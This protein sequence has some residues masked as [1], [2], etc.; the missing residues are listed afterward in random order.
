MKDQR[1]Y[2]LNVLWFK[3]GGGS[4]RYKDYLKAANSFEREVGAR[5]MKSFVP[6]ES[7]VGDFD[8][9]LIFFVEY[10]NL[11]AFK[12]LMGN[13][14]YQTIVQLSDDAIE[15]SLLIRCERPNK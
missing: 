14:D 2:M 10:P 4:E 11:Q 12:D 13:E 6:T 1:V 7:I 9:D 8:A 5:K 15:K 3:P